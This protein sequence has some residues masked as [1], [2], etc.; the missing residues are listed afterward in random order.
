MNNA[1]HRKFLLKQLWETFT[2]TSYITLIQRLQFWQVSNANSAAKYNRR[3]QC[4]ITIC[5]STPCIATLD[6]FLKIFYLRSFL[7]TSL[8][9]Y[10]L[11]TSLWNSTR[12]CHPGLGNNI[13]WSQY[14]VIGTI[15]F[16]VQYY[17]IY[18]KAKPNI[19]YLLS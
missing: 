3:P 2:S 17:K 4:A 9:S 15:H 1:Q 5:H 11:F 13:L 16:I 14:I 10:F 12:G 6:I 7:Y 18:C 8:L 19:V